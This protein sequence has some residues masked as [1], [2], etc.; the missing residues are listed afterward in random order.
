MY[1]RQSTINTGEERAIRDW[2]F[3]RFLLQGLMMM[4]L[5][6]RLQLIGALNL[7]L[8]LSVCVEHSEFA[9]QSYKKYGVTSLHYM[10]TIAFHG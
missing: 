10:S 1:Y 9:I 2:K 6:L 4:M 3:D 7:G 5:Q 8:I